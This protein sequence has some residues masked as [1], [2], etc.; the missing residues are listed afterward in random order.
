MLS[1]ISTL[2]DVKNCPDIV[3]TTVKIKGMNW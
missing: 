3:N 1:D 2:D